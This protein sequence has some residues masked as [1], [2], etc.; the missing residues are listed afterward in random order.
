MESNAS[1]SVT[2]EYRLKL[3]DQLYWTFSLPAKTI[4]T[5]V[6]GVAMF[7]ATAILLDGFSIHTFHS[8]VG[9]VAIIA[10]FVVVLMA[11]LNAFFY[12]RLSAEQKTLRWEIDQTRLSLTDGA[13]NSVHLPWSQVKFVAMRR[14]GLLIALKPMGYRWIAKRAFSEDAW[15]KIMGRAKASGVRILRARIYPHN[16]RS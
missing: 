8:I 13:G 5:L 10:P 3:M 2:G 9:F 11:V 14:T 4:W 1:E 7:S 15:V 12:F 16:S 6:I